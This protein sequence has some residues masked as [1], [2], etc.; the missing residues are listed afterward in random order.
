MDPAVVSQFSARFI[1]H[2][3]R[4]YTHQDHRAVLI[5]AMIPVITV[6]RSVLPI[7][8]PTT[9]ALSRFVPVTRTITV[10][11]VRAALV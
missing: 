10:T 11:T 1:R 7:A 3:I 8:Y 6:D 9:V 5:L 2:T 4:R